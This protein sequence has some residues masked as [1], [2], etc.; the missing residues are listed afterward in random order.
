[1]NIRIP[2]KTFFLKKPRILIKEKNT[3]NGKT[4]TRPK[5]GDRASLVYEPSHP[6]LPGNRQHQILNRRRT[7]LLLR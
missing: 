5:T 6:G 2:Q 1:M 7:K 4:Q 3:S